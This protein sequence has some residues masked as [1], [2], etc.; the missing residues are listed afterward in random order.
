MSTVS[1]IEQA[2]R[3]LTPEELAA[4]RTWFAAYAADCRHQPEESEQEAARKVRAEWMRRMG[5]AD[6]EIHEA[7]YG[8]DPPV[9]VAEEEKKLAALERVDQVMPKKEQLQEWATRY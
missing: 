3:R 2:V 1:E 7:C 4:F 9:S 6:E 5:F 8:S